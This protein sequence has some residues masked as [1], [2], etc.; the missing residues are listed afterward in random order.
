MGNKSIESDGKGININNESDLQILKKKLLKR[1]R[2]RTTGRVTNGRRAATTGRR[3]LVAIL[4]TITTAGS[5]TIIPGKTIHGKTR[6]TT[7]GGVGTTAG[8]RVKTTATQQPSQKLRRNQ[9]SQNATRT[10]IYSLFS[11]LFSLFQVHR[12]FSMHTI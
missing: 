12:S 2:K 4:A 3:V 6:P 7:H 10:K 8:P 9:Q 1:S 5:L 11:R